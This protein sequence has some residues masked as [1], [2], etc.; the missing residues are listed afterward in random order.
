MH[1]DPSPYFEK[2]GSLA[3]NL[4]GFV[5]DDAAEPGSRALDIELALLTAALFIRKLSEH[6]FLADGMNIE[7]KHYRLADGRRRSV[8]TLV[9]TLLHSRRIE[10]SRLGPTGLIS[11]T[12]E[13][14][15]QNYACSPATFATILRDYGMA[16][17]R[18][19]ISP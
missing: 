14:P 11:W 19:T 3:E 13:N 17:G 4:Q 2:L 10:T 12:A 15:E 1:A 18:E 8:S 6:G 16:K 7:R 9:N 5:A